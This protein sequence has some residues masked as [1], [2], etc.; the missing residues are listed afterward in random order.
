MATQHTLSADRLTSLRERSRLGKEQDDADKPHVV[1]EH[2]AMLAE[3]QRVV[4]AHSREI[5]EYIVTHGPL[6]RAEVIDRALTK[7]FSDA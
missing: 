7:L 2:K 6:T 4:A 5:D 3:W 1:A